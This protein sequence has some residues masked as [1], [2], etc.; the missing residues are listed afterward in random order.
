MF[1]KTKIAKVKTGYNTPVMVTFTLEQKKALENYAKNKGLS[2]A[3]FIRYE[4]LK[5]VLGY[6][7]NIPNTPK[8]NKFSK[9][10]GTLTNTTAENMLTDIYNNRVNKD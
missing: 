1:V 9:F 5:E 6:A 7:N 3:S 10:A 2:M 4:V 8:I